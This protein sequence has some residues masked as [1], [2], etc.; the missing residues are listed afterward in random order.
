MSDKILCPV[1]HTEM[2]MV[3]DH[4]IVDYDGNWDAQATKYE[5][6]A[7]KKHTIFVVNSEDVFD[8]YDEVFEAVDE[9]IYASLRN[10]LWRPSG[11]ASTIQLKNPKSKSPN[12]GFSPPIT[13]L[14]DLRDALAQVAMEEYR[15]TLEDPTI[16]ISPENTVEYEYVHAI[17]DVDE[18]LAEVEFH[19]KLKEM[20]WVDQP[21]D[22]AK[23]Q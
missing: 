5:C 13:S 3:G 12:W 21:K 19:A 23:R 20:G 1:D 10:A 11:F 4:G 18:I 8:P 14:E 17:G 2:T 9:A 7:E 22:Y 6:S 15:E 16:A